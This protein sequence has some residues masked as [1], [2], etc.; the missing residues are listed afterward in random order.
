M[1]FYEDELWDEDAGSVQDGHVYNRAGKPLHLG[2]LIKRRWGW[3]KKASS[4]AAKALRELFAPEPV[5]LWLSNPHRQQQQADLF[6]AHPSILK[7]LLSGLARGAQREIR[8]A[9]API[10]G[11]QVFYTVPIPDEGLTSDVL[12]CI[13]SHL[14]ITMEELRRITD[15]DMDADGRKI[16]VDTARLEEEW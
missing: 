11:L 15:F 7:D 8:D 16:H 2:M 4:A 13:A 10:R 3:P 12:R 1:H 6:K 9:G 14:G 5:T